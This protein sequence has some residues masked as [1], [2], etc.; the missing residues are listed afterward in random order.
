MGE[1]YLRKLDERM[2][3]L[4]FFYIRHINNILLMA[5]RR[6]P[7]RKGIRIVNQELAALKLNKHPDKT[8]I[9]RAEKGFNFSGY[10][11]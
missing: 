8:Y 11:F 6:W 4:P 2:K 5:Q 3:K 10:R 9:G 7:L 1:F